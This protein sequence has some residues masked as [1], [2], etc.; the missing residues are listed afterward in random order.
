MAH[1]QFAVVTELAVSNVSSFA[2]KRPSL[3]SSRHKFYKTFDSDTPE[4]GWRSL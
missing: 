4:A 3:R 1:C 2:Y